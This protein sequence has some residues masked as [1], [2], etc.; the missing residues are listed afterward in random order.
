M[1]FVLALDAKLTHQDNPDCPMRL[2]PTPRGDGWMC[3]DCGFEIIMQ[4]IE[5]KE[6]CSDEQAA[7]E[8]D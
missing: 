8:E 7:E 6:P 5:V 2:I 1:P 3:F 4:R